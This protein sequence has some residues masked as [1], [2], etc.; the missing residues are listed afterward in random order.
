[1]KSRWWE[2]RKAIRIVL[3]AIDV[4]SMVEDE[5]VE[6]SDVRGGRR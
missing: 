6:E 3:T 1:M 4:I 2:I 5:Y